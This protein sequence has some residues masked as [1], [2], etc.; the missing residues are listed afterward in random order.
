[1]LVIKAQLIMKYPNVIVYAQKINTT[2][3]SLTGVQRYPIFD[4]TIGEDVAFFGFDLTEEEVRA[5]PSW[6][7]VLEEQPGDPKFA[8]EV[9]DR[10]ASPYT[11]AP[12]GFGTSAGLFAQNTFLKPFRLGI[13]ATSLLPAAEG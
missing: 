6:Y 8:D 2:R 11:T 12:E 1:V 13:Q 7:F 10:D 4:A 3:T 5:D 9:T